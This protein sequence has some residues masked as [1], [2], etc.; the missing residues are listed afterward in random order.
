MKLKPKGR[1]I[2]REKSR[3]ERLRAFW[4]NTGAVVGTVVLIAVLGFVGYSAGG[5]VLRFLQDKEIIAKPN[6]S[7]EA[8][9]S[10]V[11]EQTEPPESGAESENGEIPAETE[12][13]QTEPVAVE[14]PAQITMRGYQLPT[15][16]LATKTALEA[17]LLQVPEGATHILVPL[18]VKGGGLYYATKLEDG[19]K[20]VQAAMPLES[21]YETI[22]TRGAEPVAVINTLEDQIYPLN[23]QDASYRMAGSGARWMDP[24][25]AVWMSPFSGLAVDYLS[26]I[27]KE[28][29]DAGFRS[30]LCEGL[31]YPDFPAAD[32]NNLDSRC[33]APDR[34][35][36]LVKLVESMQQAA[37]EAEFF[38]R[39]DGLDVLTNRMDA[40]TAA[41]QLEIGALLVGVNA[42]SRDNTDI[43]RGISSVHP[44]V[45]S[46]EEADLPAGE[47]SFTVTLKTE[48]K[49]EAAEAA[50]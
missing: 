12:P 28:A 10:S 30:I 8:P 13:A 21:V 31:V 42:A 14:P 41:D 27:A 38:I 40:V 48:T 2:Y 37:P 7:S 17:A 33:T 24:S 5:P 20:A 6:A 32:V 39:I 25:G 4:S 44:C 9:E 23:Y 1:K 50:E 43:L 46:W 19:I 36:S 16:A 49:K 26:N 47:E 45:L 35:T 11:S 3:F 29:N 15:S 34:Y 22:K 18:K